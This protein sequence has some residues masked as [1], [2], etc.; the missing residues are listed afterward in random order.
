MQIPIIEFRKLV[1]TYSNTIPIPIVRIASDMGI[2]VMTSS[3]PNQISGFIRKQK[4]TNNTDKV[5]IVVNENHS[6]TRKRFTIAHELAHF[7]LHYDKIGDGI[8]DREAENGIMFRSNT[9]SNRDEYAANN[10]AAEILMPINQLNQVFKEYPNI[11]ATELARK[12]NVSE[13]AMRIRLQQ[14]R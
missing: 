8:V 9:I 10:L 4:D 3:L 11:D 1:N 5:T 2:R 14:I 13:Q 12:F 6:S 7:I